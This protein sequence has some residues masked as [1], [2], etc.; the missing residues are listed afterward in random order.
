VVAVLSLT[1]AFER[2]ADVTPTANCEYIALPNK[3]EVLPFGDW[4]F[5]GAMLT[6][7]PQKREEDQRAKQSRDDKI[8]GALVWTTH[9]L[10]SGAMRLV[11]GGTFNSKVDSRRRDANSK[12]SFP[13][14]R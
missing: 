7:E 10:V 14:S 2:T 3:G 8:G 5:L 4:C 9:A 1:G 6:H 12:R 11:G 13:E